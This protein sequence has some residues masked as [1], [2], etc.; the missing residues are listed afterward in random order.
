MID[1]IKIALIDDEPLFLEGLSL[2]FS[3]VKNIVVTNTATNGYELL[4][5]LENTSEFNFP[6]IILVDIQ[7]KPL[8]GFDLVEMLKKKYSNIKIIILSSHYKTNV[9]GHMIKLGV[10]A[11][12]PKNA[13][14]KSLIT[15]IESVY[16]HGIYF[17]KSDQE[18][19]IQFMGS[20]SKRSVFNNNEELSNREIEVLKLICNEYTSQEIADKLFI[21]KRTV[22]GHRQ[23]VIDKIGAKNT[24][25]LVIYAIANKLHTLSKF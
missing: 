15:A 2:L 18:M 16:E 17:S 25:G 5:D 21:S 23:K 7:M 12:I 22:E 10:S 14:K 8:D 20:N 1:K 11:F 9:V 24:V 13:N 19:L 4:D 3:N 6:D